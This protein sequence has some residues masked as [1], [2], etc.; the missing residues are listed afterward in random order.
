MS[1]LIELKQN[2]K[3]LSIL[4]VEDSL[5]IQKQMKMFMEKLFNKVYVANDGIEALEIYKQFQPNI[6][7]TDIQMPKMDGHEFIENLNKLNHSSKI[8]VFSAYGH[9]ENVIKFLRMGVCDFIQ[10]PVNFTQ[11]TSSLLNVIKGNKCKDEE[12]FEDELLKD[13][14]IIKD[15]KSPITLI[16]HYKGLPLIHEGFI[17]FITKDSIKIQTQK[18]QTRAIIE[19][20]DTTIETDKSIIHAKLKEYDKATNELIFIDLEKIEHTPRGREV[21][22]VMPDKEFTN[23][24]FHN[25]NKY[26][27]KITSIS[28]KA[29]SFEIKHF[30]E[31]IK[32]DDNVNLTMGFNTFYSTS[33]H[34]TMTHKERVDTKAKVLKIE[35]LENNL[36]KIVMI[37]DLTLSD[38]KILEKYIYQREVEI[39]KEF[40]KMTLES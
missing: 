13:L 16:N 2:A 30:D 40:K 11:L 31:K 34:N 32:L 17:T 15:S 9:S 35:N 5:T 33:Y 28:T 8:I 14:K 18:V 24:I 37:F 20:E 39:I 19:N 29:I 22:R 12:D 3:D 10:K 1:N 27:F 23:T 26:S 25:G 36:T 6:I 4:I 7:L 38:K 21:I